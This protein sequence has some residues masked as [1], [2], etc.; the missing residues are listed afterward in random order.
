MKK[1]MVNYWSSY[2]RKF[3]NIEKAVYNVEVNQLLTTHYHYL[4][5]L[6][7]KNEQDEDTFNDTYL[8]L[9]YLYDSSKDFIEQFKYYFNL[10]KGAY[11]RDDKVA[12]YYMQLGEV[13]DKAED[14]FSEE[15]I[16]PDT[17][18]EAPKDKPS[19]QN[20]KEKIQAYALSQK[21][22]KRA[23]KKD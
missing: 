15:P 5:S 2:K 12:N 21:S 6:L 17:T 7:V 13:Y 14:S 22:Y 18:L 23:N 1:R 19:M 20:L 3:V 10:L 11:L 9:T 4:H 8:K 16:E